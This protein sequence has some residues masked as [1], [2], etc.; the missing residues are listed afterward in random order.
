MLKHGCV[1]TD[2][3]ATRR[4]ALLDKSQQLV[5]KSTNGKIQCGNLCRRML[6]LFKLFGVVFHYIWRE[7]AQAR[8]QKFWYGGQTTTKSQHLNI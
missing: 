4:F 1:L 5:K 3:V 2:V 7:N 6:T 8:S